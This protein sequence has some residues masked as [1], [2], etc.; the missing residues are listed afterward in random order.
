ML[1]SILFLMVW[2]TQ[3]IC[4]SADNSLGTLTE[5]CEQIRQLSLIAN[6][7]PLI[8]KSDT[9]T[10]EQLKEIQSSIEKDQCAIQQLPVNFGTQV[11]EKIASPPFAVACVNGPDYDNMDASLL[12]SSEYIQPLVPSELQLLI[13][14]IFQP[15]VVDYLRHTAAKKLTT[16]YNS[17]ARLT[18]LRTPSPSAHSHVPSTLNSPLQASL[19]A[20][21]VLIPLTSELSL[22][23]SNSFALAR[24][25]DHTTR[26]ERLA[27]MRLS[28]WASDLQLSLQRE[29]E[30]YESIARAER[31]IWLV[32]R[33]GEEIK[34]GQLVRVQSQDLQAAAR[35][36]EKGH[37]CRVDGMSYQLHDPLGLLRWQDAMRSQTWLALQ[38]VGSFGVV[39]GLALWISKTW[40][41][42]T[43][44]HQWAQELGVW[45]D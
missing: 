22:N 30:R 15:H 38:I 33:M 10:K 41:V 42:G 2:Y 32:E 3:D 11:I 17:G 45:H 39:G 1:S 20:S 21:G 43:S 29:R 25:A 34:D 26:E 13:N 19:S 6:V 18:A 35:A 23:T 28:K 12:M 37:L 14:Q 5:D 44:L 16:W 24:V 36:S 40:G 4:T 8:A 31:A 7:I 27:Q 9:H